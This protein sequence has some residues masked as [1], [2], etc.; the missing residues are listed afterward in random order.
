MKRHPSFASHAAR[1]TVHAIETLTWQSRTDD[2]REAAHA[3]Q[4]RLSAFLNG[5]GLVTVS[6]VFSRISAPNEVWQLDHLEIDTG[7]LSPAGSFTQWAD[8]LERQLVDALLQARQSFAG[9]LTFARAVPLASVDDSELVVTGQAPR[10]SDLQGLEHFLFYLQHGHLPWSRSA[11]AG[12]RLS[13][14]LA[15]LAQRTGPRL[16]GL[17]RALRPAGYVLTRL[18]QITPYQGLQAL[19]GVRHRELADSLDALDAR[20]LIPLQSRGRLSAYQVQQLQQMW[21]VTAFQTLWHQHGSH[22]SV[23]DV[24]RLQ[25]EL[26]T[27]LTLQLGQGGLGTWY[28]TPSSTGHPTDHFKAGHEA[29]FALESLLLTGVLDVVTPRWR[30]TQ[31]SMEVGSGV[32][33][34][35]GAGQRR[36]PVSRE[37]ARTHDRWLPDAVPRRRPL[38]AVLHR[39]TQALGGS[40]PLDPPLLTLLLEDLHRREPDALRTH[41]RVLVLR[42]G[43]L[44]QW[45]MHHGGGVAAQVI[46]A[47]GPRRGATGGAEHGAHWGESLRQFA[48][49]ALTRGAG[50]GGARPGGLSALQAWLTAFSLQQ[51]ALGE[52]APTTRQGW[53]RLWQRALA[54]WQ[55]GDRRRNPLQLARTMPR[56]RPALVPHAIASSSVADSP[57][58]LRAVLAPHVRRRHWRWHVAAQWQT[59]RKIELFALLDLAQGRIST[60]TWSEAVR[61]WQWIADAVLACMTHLA[62]LS[63]TAS[64]TS[65]SS[66]PGRSRGWHE[67]WLW[68]VAIRWA[69]RARGESNAGGW[70]TSL[71]DAWCQTAKHRF[72][73]PCAAVVRSATDSHAAPRSLAVALLAMARPMRIAARRTVPRGS[74]GSMDLMRPARPTTASR[75][76]RPKL[77]PRIPRTRNGL[78]TRSSRW[79]ALHRVVSRTERLAHV[80]AVPQLRA[81]TRDWRIRQQVA[82]WLADPALC[83]DWL[84]ATQAPERWALL[85]ALFPREI[86]AL[87]RASAALQ[88]TAAALMPRQPV[89]A[90][91]DSHWR[92]LA[93][94]VLVSG[95]PRTPG[96]L[97]RRHA[98]HLYREQGERGSTLAQWFLRVARWMAAWRESSLDGDRQQGTFPPRPAAWL[99]SALRALRRGPDDAEQWEAR[100]VQEAREWRAAGQDRRLSQQSTARNG[101]RP[102]AE[103]SRDAFD[104]VDLRALAAQVRI[105]ESHV[106]Y[107]ADAGLVL[108]A[109]YSQMLFGRL[110]LLEERRMRDAQACSRAVRCLAWLVHGHDKASEPECVLA[111]LLCGMPLS[112]PLMGDAT[113]DA[114]TRELL[115]GLLGAVIANWTALGA[116]TPAGLRETF[117]LREGRLTRERNEAGFHWRLV[118]KAGPFDMLL[119]R[120][121]WSI[122]TIKLP[123]MGDVLHV[124]WR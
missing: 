73:K 66:R 34:A 88:I 7:P 115:D 76:P 74:V 64:V 25:R 43:M 53:E 85:A 122:S 110:G 54:A 61:R 117:L 30:D 36:A 103:D 82:S 18:S 124:D 120:L 9:H 3:H 105:D 90:R 79:L 101:L 19:V 121:P 10:P 12:R 119:D 111:K 23:D 11:L 16:W 91:E 2:D 102:A 81:A 46:R 28:C 70:S 15:L 17:L 114:P 48:L 40:D 83:N 87:R 78:G 13:V 45:M 38:E 113:L 69:W 41:L 93:D 4:A 49:A 57:E 123:W 50:T 60:M 65:T 80:L 75:L 92:F 84:A 89:R 21:R 26:G 96:Y 106:H 20:L 62:E 108:L 67:A 31:R 42:N 5:P 35:R 97:A 6:R 14:W 37:R 109:T 58:V 27:A 100:E 116:T 24:Q 51:L 44:G 71:F 29:D 56:H 98:L 52:P 99:R 68:E 8:I 112:E 72:G 59:S 39:L 33:V 47:L 63:A 22:L 107:V 104:E 32:G 94:H 95:R 118:V 55:R 86:A 77:L 1:T